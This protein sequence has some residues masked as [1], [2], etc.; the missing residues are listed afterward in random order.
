MPAE[1][2]PY[3]S[4]TRAA[5]NG[6]PPAGADDERRQGPLS[7]A[8]GALLA[9]CCALVLGVWAASNGNRPHAGGLSSRPAPSVP[10]T[11]APP[12]R[13]GATPDAFGPVDAVDAPWGELPATA[14][15]SMSRPITVYLTASHDQAQRLRAAL[16]A[17]AATVHALAGAAPRDALVV[18]AGSDEDAAR[19]AAGVAQELSQGEAAPPR[20]MQ[21]VDLRTAP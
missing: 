6:S 4:D 16:E 17:D 2:P 10:R 13:A 7:A 11:P 3:V 18:V 8:A 15:P 1:C 21:I 12:V 9:L 5:A 14:A 19:I 20:P